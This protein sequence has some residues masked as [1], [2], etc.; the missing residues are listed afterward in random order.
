MRESSCL[1]SFPGKTEEPR[2]QQKLSDSEDVRSILSDHAD[3]ESLESE[4]NDRNL[5]D[6]PVP[7]VGNRK[8][9]S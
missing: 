1:L 9:N 7:E 8:Y 2:I 6:T 3:V 5:H 4:A